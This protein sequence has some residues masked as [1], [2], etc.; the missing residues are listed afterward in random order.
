MNLFVRWMGGGYRLFDDPCQEQS[1]PCL[2]VPG[3]SAPPGVALLLA[4]IPVDADIPRLPAHGDDVD[5]PIPIQVGGGKVFHGDSPRVDV[6]TLPF[7]AL[8][9]LDCVEANTASFVWLL[10]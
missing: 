2:R 3:P 9:V 10:A 5:S 8:I 1:I 4:L 6:V 7:L